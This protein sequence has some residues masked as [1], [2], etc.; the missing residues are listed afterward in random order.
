MSDDQIDAA[1]AKLE[2][3]RL[4]EL[5]DLFAPDRLAVLLSVKV[6][7][8]AAYE[9]LMM[10]W[11][12]IGFSAWND[13]K[14]EVGKLEKAKAG[15]PAAADA[16]DP[17]APLDAAKRFRKE[18]HPTLLWHQSEWLLYRGTHYEV[19]EPDKIKG[20][21]YAFLDRHS[22]VPPKARA[23]ADVLDALKGVALAER[24]AF[25]PP[26]WLDEDEM[27]DPP[28]TEILA[29]R[30]G[31]LHLPTGSLLASTPRFF[32]RN[33][34]PYD[35]D[36]KA[37]RP[38]RW[39]RFCQEVWGHDPEQITLLQ[40][41]FGYLLIP[42]TSLQKFFLFLGPTRSGKGTITKVLTKLIGKRSICS[43]TLA[44][45]GERFGLE[46]ALGKQLATV[47]DMRLGRN[48]DRQEIVGNILRIVGEDDVDVERKHI[49]GAVTG[50][51]AIRI[52][53][54]SNL[55][56][57]LPDVSG[58]LVARLVTLTMKRSFL[59]E[60]DLTLDRQLEAELPGILN[61]AIDGW[62]RLRQ[63]G[64]F[65]PTAESRETAQKIADLASPLNAFLRDC[66]V[67]EAGAMA[68]RTE[69]WRRFE[70][71]VF[72]NDLPPTYSSANYFHR[73][74]EV[75]AQHRI[76]LHRPR[77]DGKQVQHWLGLRLLPATSD[78]V[79]SSP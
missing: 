20:D 35:Y 72:A 77:I 19:V 26:C 23:V 31:L 3:M 64:H 21:V 53:I 37:P 54:S 43:P 66:C 16:L 7:N 40:E 55:L 14:T 75:A 39:L 48:T 44:K 34:L 46:P 38:E 62:R 1:V 13:L 70:D 4:D 30:N 78:G 11:R 58:A 9:R 8:R 65:T 60:E 71:Y 27:F 63:Q 74:L 59:G 69:V 15:T 57:P 17:E 76:S 33:G 29:C 45:F 36:A 73:D 67:L 32:T 42:D 61:W 10:R 28:A 22:A 56:P 41:V 5:T 6:A 12:Q 52:V 68:P 25:S 2:A 47:S 49:G 79:G 50:K 24:G 18:I 51:L